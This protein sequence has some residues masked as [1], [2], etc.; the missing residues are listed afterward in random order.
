[1]AVTAENTLSGTFAVNDAEQLNI[2]CQ[3]RPHALPPEQRVVEACMWARKHRTTYRRMFWIFGDLAKN[4]S[5][6]R[7]K[8]GGWYEHCNLEG[9]KLSD[10]REFDTDNNLWST[11]T[12][13]MAMQNPEITRIVH[14]RKAPIDTVDIKA[15]WQAHCNAGD[16]FFTDTWQQAIE[17]CKRGAA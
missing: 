12:R 10:V 4:Q 6:R 1:M 17:F 5:I 3:D 2:F 9:I 16:F 14:F 13:V 11:L 8:R 7:I 15:M